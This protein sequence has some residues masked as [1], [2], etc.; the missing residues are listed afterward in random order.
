MTRIWGSAG[1]YIQGPDVLRDVKKYA[2]I[3]GPKAFYLTDSFLYPTV[4]PIVSAG[5]DDPENFSIAV[6]DGEISRRNIQAFLQNAN[7]DGIDAV[8][9]IGGG[10]VIDVAKVVAMTLGSALIIC[11]T[12]A[13][14]D[15][16]ASAMSILYSDTGEMNE[17]MIH[18]R[19]PDLV[20]ADTRMI[21]SAPLRFFISGLGD[22]LST[23]YEGL[24]NEKTG[25]ANYVWCDREMGLPTI[26][27]RAVAQACLETLYEEGEAALA[28]ARAGVPS[29]QFE[30]VVEANILLSGIGF[31][32]VGC[33]IAHAI[34]NAFTAIPEG[35]KKMHGERVGFGTLCL[36]VGENYPKSEL[37]RAFTFC[38]KTGVPVCLEDLEIPDDPEKLRLVARSAL[39]AESWQATPFQADEDGVVAL[40]R[41]TSALGKQYKQIAG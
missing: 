10:K 31:E 35:E 28:A 30:D 18:R 5:Y 36:L 20:L 1:H 29:P 34:G 32:N 8:V 6:F 4:E 16:P 2:D 7:R 12:T 39:A 40:I 24:S 3:H 19:N 37:D 23:C 13:S 14:T 11:P 38:V 25:H 33:S 26:A 22:A 41:A 9:G 17:I 21:L 27:G 15:A